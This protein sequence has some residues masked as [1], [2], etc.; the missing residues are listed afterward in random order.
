MSEL[1]LSGFVAENTE[2]RV[3]LVKRLCRDLELAVQAALANHGAWRDAL[4]HLGDADQSNLAFYT[5][6]GDECAAGKVLHAALEKIVKERASEEA[7]EIYYQRYGI[8][9]DE[10]PA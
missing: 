9:L 6:R 2:G 3:A 8:D 4:T 5:M 10:E 1:T 7:K